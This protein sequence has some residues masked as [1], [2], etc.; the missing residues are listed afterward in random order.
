MNNEVGKIKELIKQLNKASDAYYNSSESII[1]DYEWDSL[2][3]ELKELAM[4]QIKTL[5]LF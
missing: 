3:D 2:F 5:L 1:T 4:I